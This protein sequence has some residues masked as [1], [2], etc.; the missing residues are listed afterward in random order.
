MHA[1]VCVYACDC[2]CVYVCA[3]GAYACVRVRKGVC[4]YFNIY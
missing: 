1:C 4:V 2:K 3:C